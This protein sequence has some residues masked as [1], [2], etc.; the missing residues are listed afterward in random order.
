MRRTRFDGSHC[1][2]A[3]TTDLLGDWWTPLVL[4]QLVAGETRFD[5]I[6][7]SIDI[8]RAVLSS[9]LKRLETEGVV[10]KVRYEE[11]PPRYEY[12]LTEKGIAIWDVLAAMWR[13]GDDWMFDTSSG[14]QVELIDAVTGRA[15]QPQ[16]IDANTGQPLDL[17]NTKIRLRKPKP[18]RV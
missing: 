16:T 4:R 18:L 14:A 9:R 6:A 8:S 2:I 15:V 11:R 1:P 10:E 5:Q 13:F 3:R 12:R 7:T 17:H